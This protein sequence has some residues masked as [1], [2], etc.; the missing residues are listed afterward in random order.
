MPLTTVRGTPP[1]ATSRHPR[2]AQEPALHARQRCSAGSQHP[3]TRSHS[4][5]AADPDCQPRGLAAGTGKVPNSR[6]S[7]Q[8]RGEVPPGDAPRPP[9]S[10]QCRLARAQAVGSVHVPQTRTAHAQKT[11]APGPGYPPRGRA[12]G[13]GGTPDAKR[14]SKQQEVSPQ[15]QPPATP[16][17][18]NTASQERTPRLDARS[19]DP[20]RPHPEDRGNGP[21]LPAP[22]M[23][24]RERESAHNQTPLSMA[25]GDPPGAT[26]RHSGCARQAAGHARQRASAW[27][28]HAH[29]R[30]HSK[31]L[32]FYG[33]YFSLI[34]SLD[35]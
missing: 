6:R 9:D 16:A 30:A 3:Y 19:P 2:G 26:S 4:E 24:S 27:S 12:A 18:R 32:G 5:W 8:K 14:P 25:G 29:A 15:G 31:H 20:H 17:A 28:P 23:G 11:R 7:S 1:G 35:S 10:A 21:R 34:G 33:R 22:M 13:E